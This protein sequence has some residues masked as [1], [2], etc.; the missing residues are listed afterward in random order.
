VGALTKPEVRQK[1][2]E[3]GLSTA[4]KPESQ[5]ICFVP[6]GDYR[7]LLERRLP[8]RHAALEPGPLVGEDGVVLGQH[9]GFA[10]FTVGQRKG[11]GGGFQGPMYVLAIRPETREVVV[12]PAAALESAGVEVGRLNWLAARPRPGEV[13]T[14]QL[15][16][17]APAVPAV[18]A[19]PGE[20]PEEPGGEEVLRL[21]FV[22]PQ[23]AVTPGQ[24]AV[25][26]S[27]ERVL[28][29]G[30]ILRSLRDAARLP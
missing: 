3:L 4:E 11:L 18:V 25:V 12:G 15:R 2:R 10:G 14:V 17:R 5:E 26:F 1:A 16:H 21:A 6:T 22:T 24:S 19:H 28:G 7:D 13:V 9:D 27:D 30:R 23:R 29:G 8:A 20:L